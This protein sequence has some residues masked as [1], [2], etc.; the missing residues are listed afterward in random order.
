MSKPEEKR[1][2]QFSQFIDH[3]DGTVT[4]TRTGLMWKRTAEKK[5]LPSTTETFSFDLAVAIQSNFAGHSDWRLPSIE[6]LRNLLDSRLKP[7]LDETVF[8]VKQG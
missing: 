2:G 7:M 3:Q 6:E 5:E 4:D 8:L 1:I